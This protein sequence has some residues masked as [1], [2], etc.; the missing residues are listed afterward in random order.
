MTT[1]EIVMVMLTCLAFVMTVVGIIVKLLLIIVKKEFE[2]K[3]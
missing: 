3:K 2:A 1:Y